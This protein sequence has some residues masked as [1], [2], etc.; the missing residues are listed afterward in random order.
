M[1]PTSV[2]LPGKFHGHKSLAGYSSQS[3]KESDMSE[4]L[5]PSLSERR[6]RV[7]E[8]GGSKRLQ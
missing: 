1:T 5:T 7:D 3:C 4:Q 2:F 8:L 6:C